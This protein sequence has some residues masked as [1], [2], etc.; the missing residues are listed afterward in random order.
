MS[1]SKHLVGII[2]AAALSAM[3]TTSVSADEQSEKLA[4]QLNNPVASLSTVPMEYIHDDD[5]PPAFTED[6]YPVPKGKFI[7]LKGY[8]E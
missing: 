7:Q 6:W 2:T 1:N 5:I 4:K 8:T 3:L